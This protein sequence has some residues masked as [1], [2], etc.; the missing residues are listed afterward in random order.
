MMKSWFAGVLLCLMGSLMVQASERPV[1]IGDLPEPVR[2]TVE[3]Q[4]KGA[5]IHSLSS[6]LE[7][8]K[9]IYELELT[10]DGRHRDV[11]INSAGEVFEVEDEVPLS[12]V[13]PEARAAIK[14]AAGR[15]GKILLVE[16]VTRGNA[17]TGS[18]IEAYEAHIAKGTRTTEIRV[19]GRGKAA[20][21]KD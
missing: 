10:V 5:I 4:V 7:H 18:Y 19:N 6:E 12:A 1:K 14:K 9:T 16:S 11:S 15:T 20:E 3:G 13:P 8:G 17:S 2:K 21:E